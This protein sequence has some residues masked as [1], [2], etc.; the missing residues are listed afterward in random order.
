MKYLIALSLFFSVNSAFSQ[1]T[2]EEKVIQVSGI[3]VT[4]D[5]LMPVPFTGVYSNRRPYQGTTSDYY[6]FFSI[7]AFSGDTVNFSCIGFRPGKYVVPDSLDASRISIVQVMRRDTIELPTTFV[8]PWPSREK[9]KEDFLA[10]DLPDDDIER[11][12]KNMDPERMYQAQLE[13]GMGA[14]ENFKFA[15]MQQHNRLI[16]ANQAPPIQ[17]LNPIAWAKF[18]QAWRNGDFKKKD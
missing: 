14:N 7:A 11:A 17:V 2:E 6:G 10:L 13:I 4:G 16:Y 1:L 12:K 18:I 9:F 8:Y 3:V 5:S 15:A